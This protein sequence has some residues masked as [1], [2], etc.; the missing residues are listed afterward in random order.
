MVT[1]KWGTIGIDDAASH[2]NV[3]YEVF[4]LETNFIPQNSHNSSKPQKPKNARNKLKSQM[5]H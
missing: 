3:S 4:N 1:R 5:F 2:N